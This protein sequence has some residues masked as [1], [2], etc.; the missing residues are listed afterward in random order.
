MPDDP[1]KPLRETVSLL[2]RAPDDPSALLSVLRPP[3]DPDL[4]DA[5]GLPAGRIRSGETA[6]EAALRTGREK[7]GVALGHLRAQARGR[8]ERRDYRLEMVLFECVIVEGTPTVPQ[9]AEGVTQYSR[10]KWAPPSVL[11]PAAQ[12]GSLCCRLCLDLEEKPYLTG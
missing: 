11:V 1:H 3:D 5:W 8:V 4:P 6:E 12:R 9:S 7:L 2:L 10:M